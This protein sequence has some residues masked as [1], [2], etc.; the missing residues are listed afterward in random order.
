MDLITAINGSLRREAACPLIDE[1]V[2]DSDASIVGSSNITLLSQLSLLLCLQLLVVNDWS[3]VV[4]TML[5]MQLMRFLAT[6][7]DDDEVMKHFPCRN[8]DVFLPQS[9]WLINRRESQKVEVWRAST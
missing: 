7:Q 5:H 8:I 1:I 4:R 9:N 3:A 6:L 2:G